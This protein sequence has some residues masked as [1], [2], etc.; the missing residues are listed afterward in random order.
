[1]KLRE[2]EDQSVVP[3]IQETESQVKQ[4]LEKAHA[5]VEAEVAA[6]AEEAGLVLRRAREQI[7][8]LMQ[9]RHEQELARIQAGIVSGTEEMEKMV[10]AAEGNF[11]RAVEAIV[12]TVWEG[13]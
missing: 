9:R 5:Q 4:A 2:P 8:L 3:L 13:G 12:R 10:H 7:P 11:T 1:M 6:A